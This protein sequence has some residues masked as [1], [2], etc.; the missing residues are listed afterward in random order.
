[1]IRPLLR[2]FFYTAAALWLISALS[3]GGIIFQKVPETFVIAALALSIANHFVRPFLN[4]LLLP[5]NLM[6]LGLF[7]W[8]TGIILLY[9]VTIVVKGFQI[10][11][12]DFSGFVWQGLQLPAV[13]LVG[14]PALVAVA[15]LLSIITTFLYWLSH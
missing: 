4:I 9:A 6:T 15:L 14:I 1:M 8:V 7:R 12:F 10:R 3:G 5:I 13:H 2:S 11:A